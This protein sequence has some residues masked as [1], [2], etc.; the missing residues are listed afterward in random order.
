M[1][2]TTSSPTGSGIH[3]RSAEVESLDFI[4]ALRRPSWAQ[5]AIVSAAKGDVRVAERGVIRPAPQDADKLAP[6]PQSPARPGAKPAAQRVLCAGSR[7]EFHRWL[8]PSLGRTRRGTAP[9]PRDA[10]R[11]SGRLPLDAIEGA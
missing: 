4:D 6:P 9:F 2:T 10:V 11:S 1:R 7:H 3:V 5:R 8:A